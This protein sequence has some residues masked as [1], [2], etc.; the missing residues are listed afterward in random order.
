MLLGFA[1]L[2]DH[3]RAPT[4]G[5]A[6]TRFFLGV[7]LSL[8]ATAGC[9]GTSAVQCDQSTSC[10]L[11]T[12]GI[13]AVTSGG[14]RWCSYPD[15][16]CP[17]GYRYSDFQV[18]DGLSGVCVPQ[19]IDAGVQDTPP[20]GD[21]TLPPPNAAS[22]VG[23]PATCGASGNDSCCDSP[24]VP[25]GMYNRSY[26][27]AAD[28]DSGNTNFPAT[29]SSFRLDK[30]E[31]TVERFRAFVNAGQ[32][33]QMTPPV[34]GTGAHPRIAGSG[35]DPAW[36]ANLPAN[37]TALVAAIQ[38]STT[39]QTWTDTNAH[40]PMNCVNW[41]EAMAF[42]AWDGGYLPTEAEWN[43]AAAGGNQQRA[44]AWSS[45]AGSR[46]LD[47]SH[48]SYSD[49]T[50]C[51]GDNMPGCALT[52]IAP[53]GTKPSGDGRWG[54]SDLGGNIYEWIFDW[55]GAYPTPCTDCANLSPGTFSFREYRGGSWDFNAVYM[56]SGF[57]QS[58]N[59][60][61]VR[62]FLGIRCGRNAP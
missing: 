49:G 25:G 51:V 21:M 17:S 40:R 42:C 5:E 3:D 11:A 19:T 15:P 26:D 31:V 23:L 43:Y 27:L 8:V 53:V 41:Y 9:G 4:R 62:N 46:T 28:S 29:I 52:D 7:V 61:I 36:N 1:E 54:Q 60:T 30:Y 58:D 57:R 32:G 18:G 48:A 12:G 6:M 35:W 33:T 37:T 16:S 39:F 44:Y 38:C 50:T 14:N 10:D 2:F 47:A 59:P 24:L 55:D 22:C 56:R 45:P 13:C 34:A 20:D